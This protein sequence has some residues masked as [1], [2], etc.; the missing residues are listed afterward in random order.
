MASVY[1]TLS[2]SSNGDK[3]VAGDRKVKQRVLMLARE[4]HAQIFFVML[5]VDTEF[6]RNNLSSSAF[7]P[8]PLLS[9]V[10][11]LHNLIL[12]LTHQEPGHIAGKR[13]S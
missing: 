7:A 1:K 12:M 10:R 4:N 6:E 2:S 11:R 5:T 8:G 3:A 13:Q 9:H